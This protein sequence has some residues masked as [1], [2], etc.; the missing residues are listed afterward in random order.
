MSHPTEGGCVTVR[1][2]AGAAAAI[3]WFRGG[4]AACLPVTATSVVAKARTHTHT[5]LH[6]HIHTD[7]V[8]YVL[9]KRASATPYFFVHFP[10]VVC[11]FFTARGASR[12]IDDPRFGYR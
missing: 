5:H 2:Y 7:T 1:W 8:T 9:E 6:T 10:F 11:L 4:S 12:P 3:S